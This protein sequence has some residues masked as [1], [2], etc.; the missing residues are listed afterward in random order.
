[1]KTIPVNKW[2]ER[3]FE[4]EVRHPLSER[5]TKREQIRVA[6][7]ILAKRQLHAASRS[8]RKTLRVAEEALWQ[9][10]GGDCLQFTTN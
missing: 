3:T 10:T 7:G 6:L 9:A 2:H 8:V 5:E 1:M 4:V